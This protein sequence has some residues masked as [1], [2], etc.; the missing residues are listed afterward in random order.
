MRFD[1]KEIAISE[2][3]FGCS[4]TF[5]EKENGIAKEDLT[6]DELLHSSGQYLMLMRKYSEVELEEDFLYIE[7]NDPNK[8]EEIQNFLMNICHTKFSISYDKDLIEIG[9]HINDQKFEE[10]KHI[11]KKITHKKGQ[12]NIHD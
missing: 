9:L 10:V 3:E 5:S 11:I 4:I 2:E 1:C 8:S 6:I 12:L 7:T